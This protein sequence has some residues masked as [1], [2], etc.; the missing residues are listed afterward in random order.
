MAHSVKLDVFEGPIDLL[1]QLIT[2]RR[3]DIYDVPLAT[4]AREYLDAVRARDDL[5]LDA[6]TGFVVVAATL[7]ELKSAR[8]IPAR[9]S[10]GDDASL[11]EERDLLLA[12]LVECATFREAGGF[13]AARMEAGSAYHAREVGLEPRF[14]G[15]AP[16]PLAGIT[17]EAI[18][19]AAGIALTLEPVPALD[20]SHIAPASASVRDA[21][22]GIAGDLQSGGPATFRELCRRAVGR[23]EIVVRFLALLEL[24]KA[25]AVDL[26]QAE[27]FGDIRAR[28]TGE[29]A[30][31]AVVDEVQEYAAHGGPDA[32]GSA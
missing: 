11:L 10:E 3:V 31:E 28:W 17:V 13:I 22:V 1:L 15:L 20:V 29:V 7:L 30:A 4:I 23:L 19:G 9:T 16:D 5:D 14:A 2:R 27:R 24:F 21:L 32:G 8:L 6:A 25:G 26:T 12:R 18:A